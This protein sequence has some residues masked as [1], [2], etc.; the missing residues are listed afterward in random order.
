MT[1]IDDVA[2]QIMAGFAADPGTTNTDVATLASVAYRWA[3]A[4]EV[5]RARRTLAEPAP[6]PRCG[7]KGSY[8]G[9]GIYSGRDGQ[10]T[11]IA[12]I[13]YRCGC[14]YSRSGEERP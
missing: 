5:E 4:L 10:D 9:T 3:D 13:E 6:C 8:M 2:A 1:W 12:R 14:Q 7:G 11:F